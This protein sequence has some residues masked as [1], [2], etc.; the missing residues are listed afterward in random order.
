MRQARLN[1]R[2]M[3]SSRSASSVG[4][5]LAQNVRPYGFC[6]RQPREI[7]FPVENVFRI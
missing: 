4:Y 7:E 6:P 3:G 1:S 2:V 5:G